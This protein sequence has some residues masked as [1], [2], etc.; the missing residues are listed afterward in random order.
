[1]LKKYSEL[2]AGGF[3]ISVGILIAVQIPSIKL[4]KVVMDS[5]LV[6]KICVI[7]LIAFGLGL[8]I[9]GL[10]ILRQERKIKLDRNDEQNTVQ[11]NVTGTGETKTVP[12][13]PV[14]DDSIDSNKKAAFDRLGKWA[15]PARAGVCFIFVGVFILMLQPFGFILSGII[16]LI[17]SFLVT[18][19]TSKMKSPILYIVAIVAPVSV[20]FLFVHVFKVLLPAGAIW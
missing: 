20:Y 11:I 10:F 17:C 13:N 18:G 14:V 7:L 12:Q 3:F 19:P 6:P 1:M 5:R 16:Y 4:M 9:Q 8:I 2:F 15:G